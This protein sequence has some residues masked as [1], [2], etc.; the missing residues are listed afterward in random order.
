MAAAPPTGTACQAADGKISGRG[1]SFLTR[2]MSAFISGY[3]SDVCGPVAS[4]SPS[5]TNMLVYNQT[6]VPNGSGQGQVTTSCR[7]DAFGGTDI[8]YDQG[9]GTDVPF[10]SGVLDKLNAA[11]GTN[12]PCTA[13]YTPPYQ[14]G[15]TT[16]P[17]ATDQQANVMSFPVAGSSAAIVVNLAAGAANGCPN[18]TSATQAINLAAAAVSGL[19]GGDI[20][21]WSDSRL[22]ANNPGLVNC[23][24]PV[25]RAV[26]FD[27]SGTTQIF[28]NYLKNADANR[29]GATCDPGTSWAT[30][31]QDANNTSWPGAP[32]A[33]T[34]PPTSQPAPATATCS[35]VT[36]GGANGNNSMITAIRATN[37]TFGYPDDADALAITGT[38]AVT[39]ASVRNAANTSFQGPGTGAANCDFPILLP[40]GTTT[41]AVGLDQSR[42]PSPGIDVYTNDTWAFNND[43]AWPAPFANPN[44]NHA[45]A[46]FKGTKYPICGLTFVLIYT[47][48]NNGTVPNAIARLTANQRRTLYSF[49]TYVLSPAAQGRMAAAHYAPLPASFLSTLR[50]GFQAN[51]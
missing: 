44:V 38:P 6:G 41:T 40:G 43:A 47:G 12:G 17:D 4:D 9:G 7:M 50:S 10:G 16:F 27:K 48:L 2:A 8:P 46:T 25:T 3:T 39:L 14:P 31:W 30:L 13:G 1:A 45:D 34:S 28:K 21:Q 49:I 18:R 29:S 51:F 37:G 24:V 42:D 19:A 35:A 15:P 11:P 36:N 5:G 32:G 20:K 26:R 22:T 23:N 33:P